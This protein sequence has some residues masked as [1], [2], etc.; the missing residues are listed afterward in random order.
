MNIITT[1]ELF[2]AQAHLSL[3]D[4]DGPYTTGTP[5]ETVDALAKH[6]RAATIVEQEGRIPEHMVLDLNDG[7]SMKIVPAEQGSETLRVACSEAIEETSDWSEEHPAW[8]IIGDQPEAEQFRKR[9]YQVAADAPHPTEVPMACREKPCGEWT[10][11]MLAA[12]AGKH[13]SLATAAAASKCRG[14]SERRAE[15]RRT[16][17]QH[18]DDPAIG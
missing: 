18:A 13:G 1:A 15:I 3:D 17:D 12:A 5:A 8:V 6:I 14:M 10:N 11:T 16:P 4:P 2:V 7:S 9:L